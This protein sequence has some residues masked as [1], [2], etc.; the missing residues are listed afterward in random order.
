DPPQD[1]LNSLASLYHSGQMMQVVNSC[2]EFLQ[3]YKRSLILYNILG[4]ALQAIG[5]FEEA[6][7]S[8][9]QAIQIY[10]DYVDAHYNLGNVF[11]ELRLLDEAVKSYNKTIQLNPDYAEAYNNLGVVLK[12]LKQFKK[13][14]QS[15]VKAIQL[16]PDYAEAYNNLGATLQESGRLDEAVKSYNK[17]TKLK[18][19]YAEAYSNF[20]ATLQELGRLDEAVKR[21]NQAIQ[22]DPNYAEAYSNLGVAQKELGQFEEAIN[23][24]NKAIQLKPDYAEAHWNLSLVLLSLGNFKEGWKKYEHGKFTAKED[25][26][27][28]KTP[29]TQWNGEPLNNKTIVIT[30]EQGVGDEIMFASCIP[31]VINQHPKQIIIEC[32]S[33]LAP[34]FERSFTQVI[35]IERKERSKV[36]WLNKVGEVDFQVSIGSLPNFFRQDLSNFPSRQSFLTPND[37]LRTKWRKRYN[38]LGEGI[39]IGISWAGGNNTKLKNIRSISL[40]VWS[41]IFQSKAHFIN[42]QYGDHSQEIKQLKLNTGIHIHDWDDADPLIDLDDFS[43]KISTLDLVISIDNSTVHF[44]GA[45]GVPVWILLPFVPDFR[46]MLD[47]EDSP[48]YPSAKLF[49]QQNQG[50]WEAVISKI[51]KE[52]ENLIY[53]N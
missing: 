12:D 25:R 53:K 4:S 24:Y 50:N 19:D 21:Y 47:C 41:E 29:Y 40:E 13:S 38:R 3:T 23:N 26:I 49:R 2:K 17:A 6:V 42:L 51:K 36:D 32:D 46:W 22:I 48:Y 45:L 5:E 8:Y 28:A 39:K 35:V 34:L 1:Q 7:K 37:I 30:A 44:A 27:I 15:C 14:I 16:N 9:N 43:A 20:G 31:D 33:R 11:K 18:P 52:I 10:P